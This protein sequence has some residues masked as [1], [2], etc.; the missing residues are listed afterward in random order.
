M[1]GG[2]QSMPL[3]YNNVNPPYFSEAWREFDPAQDWTI[4]DVNSLVVSIRGRATNGAAPVYVIIRDSANHTATIVHPDP[5]MVSMAKWTEW[6][7]PLSQLA[8]AGV[9]L[10][11]VKK[12]FI[13]IGDKADAKPGAAGLVYVDDIRLTKPATVAPGNVTGP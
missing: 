5:A 9:S 11:K 8:D 10:T 6:S 12:M 7:I 1:H 3:D 4:N 2:G 13:G